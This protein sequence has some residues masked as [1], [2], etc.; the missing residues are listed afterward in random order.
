MYHVPLIFDMGYGY[1]YQL[2]RGLRGDSYSYTLYQY[3][4]K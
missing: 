4:D 1:S 2:L 3:D